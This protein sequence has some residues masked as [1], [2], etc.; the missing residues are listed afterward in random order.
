M[1]VINHPLPDDEQEVKKAKIYFQLRY[2]DRKV[3]PY[4]V[5]ASIRKPGARHPR[6]IYLGYIPESKNISA[7]KRREIEEALRRKWKK[8][9]RTN[10]FP[11]IDWMDAEWK[12][13]QLYKRCRAGRA[14][15]IGGLKPLVL[16]ITPVGPSHFDFGISLPP[17]PICDPLN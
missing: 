13:E 9:F 17:P 8:E 2:K 16:S 4:K 6:Q 5:C 14:G 3:S 11:G 1:T 15:G 7:R 12:L 10:H